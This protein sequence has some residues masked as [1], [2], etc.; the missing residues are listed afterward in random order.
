MS[1]ATQHINARIE[2]KNQWEKKLLK[3]IEKAKIVE[4]NYH[5]T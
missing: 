1:K 5:N 3:K 4:K 2:R